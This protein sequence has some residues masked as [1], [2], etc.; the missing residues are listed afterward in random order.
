M[1]IIRQRPTSKW[2]VHE[3][4]NQIQGLYPAAT[5]AK[6]RSVERMSARNL[7]SSDSTPRIK[8]IY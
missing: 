3:H 4:Q 6:Y 2:P 8:L 1:L 5:P 7:I